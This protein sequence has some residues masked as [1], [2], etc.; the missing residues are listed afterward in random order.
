M[1]PESKNVCTEHFGSEPSINS[2]KYV[3][4]APPHLSRTCVFIR[5]SSSVWRLIAFNVSYWTIN[6]D[7]LSANRDVKIYR[8]SVFYGTCVRGDVKSPCD[9]PQVYCL[10]QK[11]VLTRCHPAIRYVLFSTA[12]EN[13]IPRH[14]SVLDPP[15]FV[16]TRRKNKK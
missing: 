1:R 13:V 11:R 8:R 6:R 9:S 3:C 2:T 10:I 4:T 12:Q 15:S 5:L 14:F 7:E 16:Q